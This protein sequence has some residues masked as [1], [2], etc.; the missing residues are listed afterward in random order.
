MK[1]RGSGVGVTFTFFMEFETL[2]TLLCGRTCPTAGYPFVIAFADM[3]IGQSKGKLQPLP[4]R[5]FVC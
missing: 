2:N 1:G 3:N 5:R 4:F